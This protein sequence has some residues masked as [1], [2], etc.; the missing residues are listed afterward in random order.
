ML[1][2][3]AMFQ[4]IHNT[5][6]LTKSTNR[7]KKYPEKI[8]S[9]HLDDLTHTYRYPKRHRKNVTSAHLI[10]NSLYYAPMTYIRP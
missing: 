7:C 4:N 6:R 1:N 8:P 5:I 10:Y 2:S 3:K 9:T